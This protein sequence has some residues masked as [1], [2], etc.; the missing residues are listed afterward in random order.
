[1]LDSAW[2][3]VVLSA[4]REEIWL[5]VRIILMLGLSWT[6]SRMSDC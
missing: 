2:K 5:M 4:E 1:M 3:T 6:I